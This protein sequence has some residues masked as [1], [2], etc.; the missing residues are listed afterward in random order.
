MYEAWAGRYLAEL[1]APAEDLAWLVQVDQDG[2]RP[3]EELFAAIISRYGLTQ[4]VGALAE[5]YHEGFACGFRCEPEVTSALERARR[6]GFKLA[7]VTNGPVR[8][9]AAKVAS[10]GLA[11]L[12]DAC[13]ISE[14]EGAWKPAREL[15]QAAAERCGE[16]LEDAWMIGDNPSADIGGAAACGARTIWMR[17]GRA[18]PDELAF[19]PDWE[20]DSFPE[21]VDLVLASHD[22]RMGR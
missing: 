18:W 22:A 21:G 2:Y 4:T 8:S 1:G 6:A 9:Q 10:A 11:E 20:V 12:V 15:F 14:A 3:R 19:R 7:I 16:F 17:M 13:C 5:A